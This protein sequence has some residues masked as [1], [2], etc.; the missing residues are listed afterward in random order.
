[1]APSR[2]GDGLSVLKSATGGLLK[3]NPHHDAHGRFSEAEEAVISTMANVPEDDLRQRDEDFIHQA[4][5]VGLVGKRGYFLNY[6]PKANWTGEE[7]KEWSEMNR[8]IGT[9]EGRANANVKKSENKD[10]SRADQVFFLSR[11]AVHRAAAIQIAKR[12]DKVWSKAP[13]AEPAAPAPAAPE[14]DMGAKVKIPRAL[15]EE[16]ASATE[17]FGWSEEEEYKLD[18]K[19]VK[20][21]KV[22]AVRDAAAAGLITQEEAGDIIAGL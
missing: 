15:A 12:R 4:E 1:M 2:G 7:P 14:K 21:F 18:P 6:V 9:L 3:F 13:A 16:M 11:A 10:F 8:E 5:K 22:G 17:A 20:Q 19:K